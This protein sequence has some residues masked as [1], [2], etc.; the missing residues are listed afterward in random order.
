M[1]FRMGVITGFYGT[2]RV[3]GLIALPSV[4]VLPISHYYKES[5]FIRATT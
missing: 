3:T 5:T 4:H 1:L 2:L